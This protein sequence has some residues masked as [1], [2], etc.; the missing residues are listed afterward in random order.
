V[1]SLAVFVSRFGD[2]VNLL[3]V[4]VGNDAGQELALSA[5]CRAVEN[6]PLVVEA[7]VERHSLADDLSLA[8]RLRARGVDALHVA[9]GAGPTDLLRL[10]RALS[11]DSM[12]LPST[13]AVRVRL[14]PE[15]DRMA[16]P[17][18]VPTPP[19]RTRADRRGWADRRGMPGRRWRGPE[20]RTGERRVKGERRLQLI[21]DCEAEVAALLSGLAVLTA[22]ER[23]GEALE[24]ATRLHAM[25]PRVPARA[26]RTYAIGVRRHLPR[27]VLDGLVRAALG[28]AALRPAAASVLRWVGL[29]GAEAMLDAARAAQGSGARQFLCAALGNTPEAF[30]L[31]LPLLR[32]GPREASLGATLLGRMALPEAIGPLAS[33]VDHPDD[34]VR[35][36]VLAALGEFPAADVAKPLCAALGHPV[37]RTRMAAAAA[38]GMQGAPAL[39]MP[40]AAAMARERDGNAWRAMADA[41]AAIGSVEACAALSGAALDRRTLRRP[42]GRPA[43]DRIHAV[44]ALA[45]VTA[46]CGRAAL[47]RIGREGDPP[48]RSVALEALAARRAAAG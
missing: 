19:S 26:R 35:D 42:R 18:P 2:L 40:L 41:L 37:R 44:R 9:A 29:E 23:W 1:D 15:V 12:P 22:A 48:L 45:R 8:A 46:P 33:Q 13:P 4:D 7:G 3:R 25:A 30:P 21:K 14:I 47:E 43:A 20:R 38:I 10:A 16:S 28:D 5:A 36:A 34:A 27:V 24:L 32:G 6:A 17:Q 31:V 11:H 39:A